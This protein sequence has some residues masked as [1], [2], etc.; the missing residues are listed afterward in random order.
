MK[1]AKRDQLRSA[2]LLSVK[3]IGETDQLAVIIIII[4]ITTNDIVIIITIE[5]YGK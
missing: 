4:I 1:S 5:R 3:P 2:G